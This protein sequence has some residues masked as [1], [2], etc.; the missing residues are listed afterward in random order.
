MKNFLCFI[1]MTGIILMVAC[2]NPLQGI[3]DV[4]SGLQNIKT[5]SEKSN[6]KNGQEKEVNVNNVQEKV[7]TSNACENEANA[8]NANEKEVNTNN[9]YEKEINASNAHEKEVDENNTDTKQVNTNTPIQDKTR[10]MDTTR[11]QVSVVSKPSGKTATVTAYYK[12]AEGSLI[13]VTRDVEREEGIA[14]AVISSMIDNAANRGA[15]K[16]L[17][18]YP[19][20][21][22]NTEILGINIEDGIAVI[23]FNNKLLE[24]KTE[25]EE[26][27]IFASI[28]YSLTEFKTIKGIRIIINGFEKK[29][30]KFSA[31]ISGI[32]ERDKILINSDKLNVENKTMKL[33]LYLFKYLNDKYE[34]L[35]PISKEYVGIG[36]YMLP[37]QIVRSLSQKPGKENLFTQLPENVEL[38]DCNIEDKLVTLNFNKKIKNY[39]GTAREDGL[40]KQ[41]LYSM[42]QINGVEKVRIL[43]EG[44]KDDLPEG[45]DISKDLSIPQKINIVNYVSFVQI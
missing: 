35:I 6:D 15:L 37:A 18:L 27:N 11:P 39:G 14:K 45:T 25:L 23:D 4:Q 31:N 9:V 7:S 30:L 43:I 42:K 36:D 19:V 22:E 20:L 13:P 40:L 16:T 5:S 41:V 33:D 8:S 32:L 29:K 28:V 44:K 34:Y 26:R 10:V 24:Y 17:G 21:P 2:Q 3:D 12:D 1:I 38:I